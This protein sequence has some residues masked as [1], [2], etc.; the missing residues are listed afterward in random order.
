VNLVG[1]AGLKFLRPWRSAPI[2]I[3]A[4]DDGW[5]EAAGELIRQ[6]R[7][8]LLDISESSGSLTAEEEMIEK[9]KRRPDT[10]SLRYLP[11][12][13]EPST[14]V[15]GAQVIDYSKS[16][17]AALPRM[18]AGLTIVLGGALAVL[19]ALVEYSGS[20]STG[21]LLSVLPLALFAQYY[22]SAYMRPE[23]DRQTGKILKKE[24]GTLEYKGKVISNKSF[25]ARAPRS[26]AS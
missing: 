10:I 11:P 13:A 5:E 24:L 1:F 25:K 8:I 2:L 7:V 19:G 16:W 23:V 20:R 12:G 21:W 9:A 26:E 15:A 3:R 22:Y 17:A 6:A 14:T 18:A 4:S